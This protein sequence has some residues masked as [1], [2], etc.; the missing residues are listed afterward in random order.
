MYI[1]ISVSLLKCVCL[2][3]VQPPT[4]LVRKST[5]KNHE[6][7]NDEPDAK[8]PEGEHLAQART[9]LAD[10][11]GMHDECR[12]DR[13]APLAALSASGRCWARAGKLSVAH[14]WSNRTGLGTSTHR[15][16]RRWND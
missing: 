4:L 8:T 9:P 3:M 7:V 1:E 2:Q 10:V 5:E 15:T 6:P 11:E 14:K 12:L 16:S 13:Q